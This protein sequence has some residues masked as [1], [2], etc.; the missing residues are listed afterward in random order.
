MVLSV[1]LYDQS[2][3]CYVQ[4]WCKNVAQGPP[5]N[6]CYPNFDDGFEFGDLKN[7][8]ALTAFSTKSN[9]FDKLVRKRPY[10]KNILVDFQPFQNSCENALSL[11]KNR[12]ATQ[13]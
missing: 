2:F 1:S 12:R 7:P 8:P 3:R 13:W 9:K 5:R 10:S 4:F 6:W 11:S